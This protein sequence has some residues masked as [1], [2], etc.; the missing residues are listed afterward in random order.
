MDASICLAYL[1][2]GAEPGGNGPPKFF[3]NFFFFYDSSG[4]KEKKLR[5]GFIKEN[6][7]GLPLLVSDQYNTGFATQCWT[8][9]QV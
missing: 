1:C 3:L 7:M 6:S 2:L 4:K 9:L 5:S 8:R